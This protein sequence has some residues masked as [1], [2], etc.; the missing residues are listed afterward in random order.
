MTRFHDRLEAGGLLGQALGPFLERLRQPQQPLQPQLADSPVVLALPRGGIPVG[1]EV[2][3]ALNAA[4]TAKARLEAFLVRK[5]GV[6]GNPELAMG[7]IASNGAC[8]LNQSLIQGLGIP[9]ELVQDAIEKESAI[10]RSREALYGIAG[11][12]PDLRLH[13]A[14]LVDDGAATGAS[15]RVAVQAL[16]QSRAGKIIVALPVAASQAAEQLRSEA[17]AALIL[18]ESDD[19]QAVGQWYDNFGQV[20]DAEVI[21]YL[22]KA[23]IALLAPG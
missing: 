18:I 5:L 1:F 12:T 23:R 22:R 2:A 11:K 14:I 4:K 15:M 20:T 16:R 8:L 13:P 19:F 21:D 3:K 6:P 7:A 17:D 10:L 9:P